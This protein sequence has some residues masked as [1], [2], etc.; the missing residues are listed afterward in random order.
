MSIISHGPAAK[1]LSPLNR[2]Q[3]WWVARLLLEKCDVA[4]GGQ[5]WIAPKPEH[6]ASLGLVGLLI[7]SMW[8]PPFYD[9]F[10]KHETLRIDPR[11][12]RDSLESMIRQFKLIADVPELWPTD[13]SCRALLSLAVSQTAPELRGVSH[14]TLSV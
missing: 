13:A 10:L 3:S 2:V 11:E 5:A 12:V 1:T 9:L 7:N 6:Q 4:T 8:F 14:E